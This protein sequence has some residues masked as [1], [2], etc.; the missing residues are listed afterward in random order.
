MILIH[1]EDIGLLEE[2][3]SELTNNEFTKIVFDSNFD[4][5]FLRFTQRN[6][7]D[8]FDLENSLTNSEKFLIYDFKKV[9]SNSKTEENKKILEMLQFLADSKKE[10]IFLS[11]I[12]EPSKVYSK[13]FKL[14]SIK[15]LNKL[16]MKN[17]T[18]KLLK[19]NNLS[20]NSNQFEYLMDS[21]QPDS[22][23]IKNEIEKLSLVNETLN[24]DTITKIISNDIS[25]NTFELID[26][27]FNR[28]YEKIV[29]Q[30]IALENSKIDFTEI[31][32]IMVS[33]L[34]SLKL[35]RLNYLENRS[36]RKICMDFNVQQFQIDKWEKLILNID[37]FQ[38]DNLLNNLLKLNI[39]YLSG[40]KS[41]PTYLKIILLNGGEYGL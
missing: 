34:F 38:I 6:L 15:K 12:K 30:I 33:Q 20:L 1:G 3:V 19:Q 11:N 36:Y 25:K 31:F 37:V 22:L 24:M 10:I 35:Y 40:K 17:Y 41:L 28:R 8:D 13:F 26:N 2:K 29:K 27:F 5:I 21:L 9:L 23:L 39:L 14:I 7:F 4:D 32:N 16:T 18:L